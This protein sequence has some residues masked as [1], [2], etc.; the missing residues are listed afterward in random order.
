MVTNIV[1]GSDYNFAVVGGQR[2]KQSSIWTLDFSQLETMVKQ[3]KENGNYLP[4]KQRLETVFSSPQCLNASFL[5]P[6][7]CHD[8]SQTVSGLDCSQ[9]VEAYKLILSLVS[10]LISFSY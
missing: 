10:Q 8:T 3:A 9:I 1:S 4:I 7:T 2:P 5:D 6:T